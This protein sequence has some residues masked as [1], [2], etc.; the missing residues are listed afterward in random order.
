VTSQFSQYNCANMYC[1]FISLSPVKHH[2]KWAR[3]SKAAE[4]GIEQDSL[5]GFW[6]CSLADDAACT[7]SMH[8]KMR[9]GAALQAHR[10]SHGPFAEEFAASSKVQIEQL[11]STNNCSTDHNTLRQRREKLQAARR[12]RQA[13]MTANS[14]AGHLPPAAAAHCMGINS[15]PQAVH[16]STHVIRR[17]AVTVASNVTAGP[18]ARLR[19][20][21]AAS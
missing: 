11:P 19:H 20:R 5:A 8:L 10:F 9:R 6:G 16:L 1:T 18:A 3:Y 7:S 12:M 15:T 13:I 17:F 4:C 21:G 14:R 2:F